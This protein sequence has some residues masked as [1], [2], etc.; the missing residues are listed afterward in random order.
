MSLF[1][2]GFDEIDIAAPTGASD[3]WFTPQWLLDWLPPI[4]LD[5]CWS[6]QSSV[7]AAAALDVRKGVDGLRVP[8]GVVLPP[9]DFPPGLAIVFVNPPYSDCAAWVAK[10]AEEARREH[11]PI[12]ALIPAKPGEVYW[13]EHVWGVAHAVGFLRG[14]VP[15]D[16][17]AGRGKDAGTFGSALVV[18]GSSLRAGQTVATIAARS[19]SSARRPKWAKFTA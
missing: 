3:E 13:H 17:V 4:A 11:F 1:L 5:P 9:L 19:C 14:R 10:C 16:T 12:V 15:F 6:P 2:P 18:W 8:W 7:V